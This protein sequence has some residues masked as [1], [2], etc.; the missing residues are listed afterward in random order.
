MKRNESGR[1]ALFPAYARTPLALLA[2]AAVLAYYGTRLITPEFTH[3]DFTLPIDGRI[4][5]VPAFAAVYVLAYVQWI[6]GYILIARESR[7]ACCEVLGGEIISKLICMALFIIIPTSMVRP[8]I[9]SEDF[10]SRI[11]RFLYSIDAPDNLFP[12]IHCLESMVCIHGALRM[13]RIG[14]WYLWLTLAFSALV[15]IS[16][17]LVK[18]HVILDIIAGIAVCEIGQCIARRA[19]AGRIFEGIDARLRRANRD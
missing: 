7:E 12:S 3:F 14:R 5:F 18:Q 15:F 16:T 9:T 2:A 17:V 11:M 13:K 10:F 19:D 8:E 6:A 1:T 4:P